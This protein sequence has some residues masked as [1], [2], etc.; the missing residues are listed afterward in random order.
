MYKRQIKSGYPNRIATVTGNAGQVIVQADM[1]NGRCS[2]AFTVNPMTVFLD[3]EPTLAISWN[4]ADDVL[5]EY[6]DEQYREHQA[7]KGYSVLSWDGAHFDVV[8]SPL[9][10][11]DAAEWDLNARVATRAEALEKITRYADVGRGAYIAPDYSVVPTG[12][13]MTDVACPGC[14]RCGR[15]LPDGEQHPEG[16]WV[17]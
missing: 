14:P 17:A 11:G 9:S 6:A 16:T 7:P 5:F 8:A 3:F 4:S 10:A 2:V 13:D 12:R 1:L 15:Y